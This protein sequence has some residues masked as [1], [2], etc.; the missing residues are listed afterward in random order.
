MKETS[1]WLKA[2]VFVGIII[3]VAACSSGSDQAAQEAAQLQAAKA[4]RIAQQ[5]KPD[6]PLAGT[7]KAITGSKGNL[8]LELRF[9]ML[10]RPERG[11]SMDI[12]LEFVPNTDLQAV[13]AVIK[14]AGGLQIGADTKTSFES[15]KAGDIKEYTFTATPPKSGIYL[16][17]VE[18]TVTRTTGDN[19]YVFSIPIGVPE[20]M[21]A[22]SSSVVAAKPAGTG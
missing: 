8:P 12:K 21:S 17:S 15:L 19:A 3:G 22:A 11:K 9:Q 18:V 20:P 2:S 5:P 7:V 1:E 4:K 13:S 16:A 10:S 6:D 14:S